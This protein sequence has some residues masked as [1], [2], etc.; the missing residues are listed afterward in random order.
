MIREATGRWL[1]AEREGHKI[2]RSELIDVLASVIV[3]GAI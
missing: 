1:V 2:R 3:E